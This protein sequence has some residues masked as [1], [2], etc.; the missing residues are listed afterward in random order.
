M[1]ILHFGLGMTSFHL[2]VDIASLAL[3]SQAYIPI[4]AILALIFLKEELTW[5]VGLGIGVAFLGFAV[6]S[7]D[8]VIF[9]QLDSMVIMLAATAVMA[10]MVTSAS[11]TNT[12]RYPAT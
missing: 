11:F 6:M 9:T 2:A 10:I 7:F 5:S 1:G 8:P 3:A 12:R 4:S